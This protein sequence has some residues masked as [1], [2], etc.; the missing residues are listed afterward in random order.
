MAIKG[1]KYI[2][3]LPSI[4][5]SDISFSGLT[6]YDDGTATYKLDLGTFKQISLSGATT[7]VISPSTDRNYVSDAISQVLIQTGGYG[8]SGT[9]GSSGISGSSGTSGT[10]GSS[11]SSGR[12]GSSGSS[13]TSGTSGSSGSSGSSGTSGTSG[14]NGSSGTSGGTGT[15]GTSGSSGSSGSS[16]LSGTSGTSGSSGS[17]GSSGNYAAGKRILKLDSYTNP[18]INTNNYD[19]VIITGQTADITS[20][21]TNLTG[22]PVDG[23]I[24]WI[25]ITGTA[26]RAITWGTSF[27]NSTVVLP[28]TTVTTSRLDVGFVYNT[29]TTKWRCVATS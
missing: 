26:A 8:S 19:M 18:T 22:A 6:V 17:S 20:F 12:S 2:S 23:Q 15:S 29:E 7:S 5:L 27:E 4:T 24:L 25:A 14:S 21:T 16:G 11:G 1:K 13:G 3:D 10:D 28:T 9:D